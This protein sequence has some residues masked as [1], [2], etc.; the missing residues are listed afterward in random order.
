[1]IAMREYNKLK[2]EWDEEEKV[3][4]KTLEAKTAFEKYF[5]T[6][7][8]YKMR[9][10]MWRKAHPW[11]DFIAD[12]I[13]PIALGGPEFDLNNVQLLC[14]RCNK[15]KTVKDAFDIAKKRQVLKRS[16]GA[17]PLT[18]FLHQ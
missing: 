4:H 17:S 6:D 9:E 18:D 3:W 12:H 8:E 13:I 1:M 15:E 10:E 2:K 11:R 16:G 14:E 7:K 5:K